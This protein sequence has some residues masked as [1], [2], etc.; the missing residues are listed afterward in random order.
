MRTFRYELHRL[1]VSR[2]TWWTT[3]AVLFASA[4]FAAT[5]ASVSE[6]A[7]VALGQARRA[8]TAW[9]PVLPFPVVAGGAGL[10]G[11]LAF[12]D[13]QSHPA[14]RAVL[15]PYPRRIRLTLA[16]LGVL[17]FWSLLLSLA[18]LPLNSLVVAAVRQRGLLNDPAGLTRGTSGITPALGLTVTVTAVAWL[19]VLGAGLL[20]SASAGALLMLA[21]PAVLEPALRM[22]LDNPG[23]RGLAGVRDY[24]PF[25]L[26]R[27]WTLDVGAPTWDLPLLDTGLSDTGHAMAP[28]G[29]GVLLL[30]LYVLVLKRRRIL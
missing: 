25:T 28:L 8:V 12:R 4:V 5:D 17:A 23:L 6:G 20:R 19:G 14:L 18:T 9:F 30:L 21:V 2:S 22:V 1:W 24:L 16:K 13:E 15:V 29:P 11:A 3:L 7:D 27:D 26:G 10:L